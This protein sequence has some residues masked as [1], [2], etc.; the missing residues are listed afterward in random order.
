MVKHPVQKRFMINARAMAYESIRRWIRKAGFENLIL[1]YPYFGGDALVWL[2]TTSGRMRVYDHLPFGLKVKKENIK[3]YAVLR[4][5]YKL[6]QSFSGF[7]HDSVLNA[8]GCAKFPILWSLDAMGAK[9]ITVSQSNEQGAY[10]IHFLG[11][12]IDNIIPEMSVIEYHEVDFQRS[13]D[14]ASTIPADQ[15]SMLVIK[16]PLNFKLAQENLPPVILY[17]DNA[18]DIE[19]PGYTKFPLAPI[20]GDSAEIIN[21]L[22]VDSPYPNIGP[23]IVVGILVS[24]SIF[25]KGV[26]TKQA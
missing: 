26:K 18:T 13:Q 11:P 1:E 3:D 4:D 8:I 24:Y 19:V 21:R 14:V 9:E 6:S 12:V 23:G 5:A 2:A 7:G 20:L 15:D 25:V 22:H 17:L 10:E 16:A